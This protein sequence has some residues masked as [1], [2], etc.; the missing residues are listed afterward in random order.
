[1]IF[2]T[3]VQACCNFILALC[4]DGESLLGLGRS[5]GLGLTLSSSGGSKVTEHWIVQD[6]CLLGDESHTVIK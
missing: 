4:V 1:M 5:S 6:T 3:A 2:F